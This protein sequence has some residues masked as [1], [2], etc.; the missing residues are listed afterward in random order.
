MENLNKALEK[1][2]FIY[3]RIDERRQ[4]MRMRLTELKNVCKLIRFQ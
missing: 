3:K 4:T 2:K 1:T